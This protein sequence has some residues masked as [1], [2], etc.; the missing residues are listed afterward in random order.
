MAAALSGRESINEEEARGQAAWM[1]VEMVVVVVVRVLVVAVVR[2]VV[3]V[4]VVVT[5]VTVRVVRMFVCL[6]GDEAGG[7]GE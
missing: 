7:S 2:M 1:E 6:F 5:M 4:V 3:V